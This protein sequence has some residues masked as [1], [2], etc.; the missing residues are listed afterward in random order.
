VT[1]LSSFNIKMFTSN[2]LSYFQ[3]LHEFPLQLLVA[4]IYFDKMNQKNI[5]QQ[6]NQ[7]S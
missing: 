2:D 1:S 3:L 7:Q 5:L 6:H 4:Q